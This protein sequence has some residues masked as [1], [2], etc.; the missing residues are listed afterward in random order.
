MSNQ[1]CEEK[2]EFGCFRAAQ[3]KN[4]DKYNNNF[5][6]DDDDAF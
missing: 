1:K 3:K 2:Q 5:D 4:D 6:D